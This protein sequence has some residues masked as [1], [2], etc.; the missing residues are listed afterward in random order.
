MFKGFRFGYRSAGRWSVEATI[1]RDAV[2]ESFVPLSQQDPLAPRDPG[3]PR[4]P[5]TIGEPVDV[6]LWTVGGTYSLL[7]RGPLDL[8]A[9]AAAGAITFDQNGISDEPMR[10]LVTTVGAG[11]LVHLWRIVFLRGDV[12]GYA[13]WCSEERDREGF[14]CDD[15]SMLGHLEAS[16]GVQLVFHP[17][18]L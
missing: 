15:G 7:R 11:A 13:Q 12:R 2:G 4:P 14:A 10:D 5:P 17:Y 16:L 1:A 6:R 8:Y 3:L 18:D 9:S